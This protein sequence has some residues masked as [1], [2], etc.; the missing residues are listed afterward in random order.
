MSLF[1]V[2][3][4][5]PSINSTKNVGGISNLTRLLIENNKEV[6]YIHFVAGKQDKEERGVRWFLRQFSVLFSFFKK[7][8]KKIDLVHINMPLEKAGIVRD[9]CFTWVCRIK[10]VPYI[11]HLRG[12]VYSKNL[13]TPSL[14][15]MLIK[16]SL[17][18][19]KS[20]IVLGES[21]KK[22]IESSYHIDKDKIHVLPNSVF[23]PEF[24]SKSS[25]TNCLNLLY[26]GRLDK[27]KGLDEMVDALYRLPKEVNYLLNIA[28]EG[29]YKDRLLVNC[30]M[31]LKNKYHYLGVVSGEVKTDLLIN[32]H[33]FLLPSYFEGLPNALLE[34][35]SY[36]CVPI[37]TPVGSIPEV[38]TDEVNG[39][40][41]SV[42][43][44]LS[45]TEKIKYLATNQDV[46]KR[47]SK[48][49]FDTIKKN[50]DIG[51]YMQ[52]LNV[53]YNNTTNKIE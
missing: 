38:V 25:L 8:N 30:E 39:L 17:L 23:L 19:A 33:I 4:T 3:I 51:I 45:I 47:L 7:V 27:N 48:N 43:D 40:I 2:L 22:Y 31:K 10:R 37:V 20:I 11:L 16:T 53:I 50:Y 1:S 24:H 46:M 15:K 35:M 42:H 26:L 9:F 41:V 44:S 13:Q 18:C 14:L 34:A 21:E 28:G 36:G 12:G 5:S 52:R 6:N 32:T 49:A 29:P